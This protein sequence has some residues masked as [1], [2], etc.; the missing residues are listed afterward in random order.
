MTIQEI[1]KACGITAGH[2]IERELDTCN[3]FMENTNYSNDGNYGYWLENARSVDSAYA[4]SVDGSSHRYLGSNAAY[5]YY[6]YGVRPAI[7][8]PKS[9]IEY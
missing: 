3:Y 9:N 1:N 8:V 5:N 2:F 7:E 6:D 4:W